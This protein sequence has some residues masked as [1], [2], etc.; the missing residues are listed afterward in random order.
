[1]GGKKDKA[2]TYD[3]SASIKALEKYT[4]LEQQANL[5]PFGSTQAKFDTKT[6]KVTSEM[7][8]DPMIEQAVRQSQQG[9]VDLEQNQQ[10]AAQEAYQATYDPLLQS[11][12]AE[13]GN[14]FSGLGMGGRRSSLGV[15]SMSDFAEQQARQRA[16]TLLDVQNQARSR[17]LNELAQ[18]SQMSY[19]PAQALL[20]I[21]Q[22]QGAG[23]AG[24]AQGLGQGIAQQQQM[25][26]QS[27]M[28][29]AASGGGKGAGMG[30]ALGGGLNMFAS[31]MGKSGGK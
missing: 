26:A 30:Q 18:R 17:V 19:A 4:P 9:L 3:P 1:M 21:G 24:S 13:L 25:A 31:M 7:A 29:A 22:A 20:G 28:Q 12:K 14:Y 2:P 11:S 8:L 15:K 16:A 23:V 6:K 10:K 27:E 5:G